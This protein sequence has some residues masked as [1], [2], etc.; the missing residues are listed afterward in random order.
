MYIELVENSLNKATFV[1]LF[2]FYVFVEEII[3]KNKSHN[4]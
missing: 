3:S 1:F 4:Q 2:T